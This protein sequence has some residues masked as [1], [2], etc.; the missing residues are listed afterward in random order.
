MFKVAATNMRYFARSKLSGSLVHKKKLVWYDNQFLSYDTY[1]VKRGRVPLLSL[2]E[3]E[4][5]T[6]ILSK[7][8]NKA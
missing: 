6:I 1:F 7:S 5:T 3:Q 2:N 8:V 4:E